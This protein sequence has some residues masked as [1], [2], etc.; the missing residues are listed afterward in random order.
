MLKNI[1][2]ILLL[3]AIFVANN[4][5]AELEKKV[6]AENLQE[7]V[8][9]TA[10]KIDKFKD[11]DHVLNFLKRLV[12]FIHGEEMKIHFGNL[13]NNLSEDLIQIFQIEKSTFEYLSLSAETLRDELESRSG[14]KEQCKHLYKYRL[15]ELKKYKFFDIYNLIFS[16][17]NEKFFKQFQAILCNTYSPQGIKLI[18]KYD[19]KL[20]DIK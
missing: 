12:E 3:S 4:Y 15:A 18:L 1:K 8:V 5:S 10:K 6:N 7:N 9:Q 17:A 16:Q 2:F 11:F 14:N 13:Y 19:L 20:E